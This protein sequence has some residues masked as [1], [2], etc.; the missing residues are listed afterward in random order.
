VNPRVP[1]ALVVCLDG[2]R[3]D[4]LQSSRTP[5]LDR[6]T[7]AGFLRTSL[8]Y[9]PPVAETSTGPGVATM[10][11]GV[12][13]GKHNVTAN[14]FHG[15][16]LGQY[17]DFLTRIGSVRPAL[18]TLVAVHW[19]PL[20]RAVDGGPVFTEG[21][22]HRIV[23]EVP[24]GYG[25]YR[26][27][28]EQL[29]ASVSQVLAAGAVDAA[30]VYFAVGDWAGHEFGG[31]SAIYREAVESYDGYLG[32]LLAAIARRPSYP[33][34]DWLVLVTTDHGHL[35]EGGHGGA[36]A[37]ERTV[38]V[39]GGRLG[40]SLPVT[41]QVT[42]VDIVPTVLAHLGVPADPAWALDG[43]VPTGP[44]AGARASEP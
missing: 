4:V 40:Q 8:I 10:V 31:T 1:K 3:P 19:A 34:E 18:A 41:G 38:F 44:D 12:W 16:R 36:S 17:P 11:T 39:A 42:L 43:T 5:A 24:D 9:A 14:V 28:D 37:V 25:H 7:E 21:I 22:T 27:A 6:L 20:G 30:F 33:A 26:L 13:P 29:A 35:D 23:S 32:A 2:V 15:H